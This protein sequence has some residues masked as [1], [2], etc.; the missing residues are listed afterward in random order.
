MSSTASSRR[1]AQVEGAYALV[2]LTNDMVLAARDPIGIRPLVLGW[3]GDSPG[4]RVRNLRAREQSARASTAKS[5]TAKSSP[6]PRAKTASPIIQQPLPVPAT[7]G[8]SMPLRV[9][10]FLPSRLHRRRQERLRSAQA[11]GPPAG[12]RDRTS[13]PMSSFLFPTPAWPPRSAMRTARGV[14]YE[15]GII[16]SHYVGRT[17]IQPT[18][19]ARAPAACR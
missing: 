18:Q 16:R 17:F 2:C 1:S 12:G 7:P 15:M 19:N 8:A 3:I 9:R 4:A 11:D 13:A 5:R 10:L 14:P 6:S